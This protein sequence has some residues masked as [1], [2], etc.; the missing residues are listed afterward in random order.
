M[1]S[2]SDMTQEIQVAMVLSNADRSVGGTEKQAL[3][4]ANELVLTGVGISFLS[5]RLVSN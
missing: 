3:S 2:T 5:K 4:R 1:E